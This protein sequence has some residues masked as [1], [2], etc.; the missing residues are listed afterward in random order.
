MDQPGKVANSVR[1]R[2]NRENANLCLSSLAAENL[3][4]RY[5]FGRPFSLFILHTQTESGA[6]SRDSSRFSRRCAYG[7][8]GRRNPRRFRPRQH[9][10]GPI[11]QSA[12]SLGFIG[13]LMQGSPV[14]Y[15][16]CGRVGQRGMDQARAALPG[17]RT[18]GAPTSHH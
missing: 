12:T 13:H 16:E 3:V 8:R 7:S 4:S 6:Y 5:G 17:Q 1:G 9:R 10:P 14:R 15:H 18:Q 11:T 2:L